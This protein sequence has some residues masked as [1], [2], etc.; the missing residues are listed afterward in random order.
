[1]GPI[2]TVSAYLM[3]ACVAL[4][5]VANAAAADDVM[6]ERSDVAR[7]SEWSV[8]QIALEFNSPFSRLS[9]FSW[10]YEYRTY[11]GELPGAGEQ[12]GIKNLF[13]TSW[14]IRLRNGKN[15][16]IR[17]MLPHYG[18]QPGWQP[19]IWVE[20]SE[21]TIRQVPSFNEETEG[22]VTGHDHLGDFAFDIS[23]G[24]VTENGLISS[25]GI[26]SV[27]NTSEDGS[28][29]RNSWLMGP[30][31]ALG[32]F[33]DWGLIGMRATH[34]TDIYG[35][36]P[37]ALPGMHTNETTLELFFSYAYANG[38]QIES[39]PTIL[40]DWEAVSGNNWS[41]PISAGL[42]RTFLAGRMPMRL[43][44]DLQHFVLSPDRFGPEWLFR[45]SLAAAFSRYAPM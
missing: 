15:L 37:E 40:Y 25:F 43:A 38:W 11:Q 39:K 5:I 24:S 28:A 34:L 36:G 1:M 8:D 21:S 31:V 3:R 42:S 29:K 16:L 4:A 41:V 10:D 19:N 14:P 13:T 6:S 30:Q 44:F 2:Q 35:D 22:F 23:Y 7:K 17:A 45:F 9:S 33:T 18:N 32:Q 27:S 20:Y 12:T 26:A